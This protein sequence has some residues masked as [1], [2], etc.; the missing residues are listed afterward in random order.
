[1]KIKFVNNSIEL[2]DFNERESARVDQLSVELRE[3]LTDWSSEVRNKV[4]VGNKTIIDLFMW[5]GMSTWWIGRLVQKNSFDSN[6][7]LNQL[8]VMYICKDLGVGQIIKVE[9]DD[10]IIIK[11][12]LAN[13]KTINVNLISINQLN[14]FS[15]FIF[16]K[17]IRLK[18]L[19]FSL[20][21]ELQTYILFL[22]LGK[23]KIGDNSQSQG[24]WFR[25]LFPIN[26][27]GSYAKSDR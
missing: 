6:Q 19:S 27:I 20:A 22:F 23:S 24:I 16:G 5:E 2:I 7:W 21:K 11:T 12:L 14:S 8:L 3:E 1:M 18:K 25:T 4:V 10:T 13:K 9:T 15:Y 17:L 26:W